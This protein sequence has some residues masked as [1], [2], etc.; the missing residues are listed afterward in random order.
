MAGQR[1]RS[2][3]AGASRARRLRRQLERRARRAVSAAAA[4][5]AFLATISHEMREPLNGVLGMARLLKDTPLDAE[6]AG[7]LDAM[8]EAGE[9]LLT[10]VNDVLDLSRIDAGRLELAPVS[11]A[12]RPFLERVLALVEPR[13]R[14]KGLTLELVVEDAVPELVLADPARLRQVLLNL[15]G[16]AIKFTERGGLRLSVA[17]RSRGESGALLALELADSGIGMSEAELARLFQP[18]AQASAATG[19]L[20]GGS[21]LG[22][23][24]ARRIVEAMGGVLRCTSRPGAGTTFTALLPVA[25]PA[26]EAAGTEVAAPALAGAQLLIVDPIERT[27]ATTRDL[28]SLWGMTVRTAASGREAL[29][30]LAEA[31]ARGAPFDFALVDG[32]LDDL[33]PAAFAAR[34]RADETLAATRLVLLAPAG[35]RGDARRAEAAGFA[36]YLAKPVTAETLMACLRTLRAGGEAE[37]LT[38]HSLSERR[39]RPLRLLVVDDNALNCR[40]LAVL[41]ERAGH[42][43]VT[44]QSG[45]AALERLA[46][47]PFDLVLMDMQM[48]GLD[49]LE[50]TRRIRAMADPA[51]AATPVV[52]VTAN[53]MAD[54]ERRCRAAGMDGYLTKP[55]DGASLLATVDRHLRL[56]RATR[57]VP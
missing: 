5:A 20:Y 25:L 48:P 27:R 53:A 22:L 13:A 24:I 11:V 38:R 4:R 12:L 18:W 56:T 14:Q 55:V 28:A 8:L 45:T 49:G 9:A 17:S 10:L 34:L 23:V 52:A 36:A 29:A 15:L 21:G 40:L 57:D 3:D 31:A 33:E 39:G 26:R 42:T 37:I 43:V 1:G 47:E 41:L 19:R 16:N 32:R 50:T 7:Y 35:L 2:F 46:A 44:V 51:R 54:D 30:L 6:Q